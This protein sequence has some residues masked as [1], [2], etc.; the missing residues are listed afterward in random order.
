MVAETQDGDASALFWSLSCCQKSYGTT[1]GDALALEAVEQRREPCCEDHHLQMA[2][3]TRCHRPSDVRLQVAVE[4][5]RC[6]N[7]GQQHNHGCERTW[8]KPSAIAPATAASSHLDRASRRL[9]TPGHP[10]NSF[11]TF[12]CNQRRASAVKDTDCVT[13]G[14]V[15]GCYV[16]GHAGTT[17]QKRWCGCRHQLVQQ[18][19]A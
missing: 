4:S 13:D 5:E 11:S 16:C 18:R 7:M 15:S 9:H 12:A 8:R 14:Q 3:C 1:H 17:Y 10:V 2:N 6:C 19:P